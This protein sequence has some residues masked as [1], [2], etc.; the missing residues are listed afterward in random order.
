MEY[1]IVFYIIGFLVNVITQA[2]STVMIH[3]I[4]SYETRE[5][6]GQ[7]VM[8]RKGWFRLYGKYFFLMI[9][10]FVMTIS[11]LLDYYKFKKSKFDNLEDYIIDKIM[12]M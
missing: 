1:V 10:P 5:L 8:E 3:N 12:R 4:M 7:E 11:T 6:M 2:F 9:I